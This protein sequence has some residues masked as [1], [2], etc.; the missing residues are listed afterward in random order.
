LLIEE[1]KKFG[2]QMLNIHSSDFSLQ[3]N[4]SQVSETSF[5]SKHMIDG[6]KTK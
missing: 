3:K 5:K 6:H 4:I 1:L 2:K